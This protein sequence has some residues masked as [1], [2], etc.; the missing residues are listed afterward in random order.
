MDTRK[1]DLL[2]ADRRENEGFINQPAVLESV[3]PDDGEK[4]LFPIH[5]LALAVLDK[6]LHMAA[7]TVSGTKFYPIEN[8]ESIDVNEE[9][10]N[11]TFSSYGRIYTVRAFQESDG[12]W[13]SKLGATVPAESLE[14]RYMVE[15][16]N[17]FSPNAPAD[18]ENLYAAVND[19]GEVKF[20]VYSSNAGMYTRSSEGWFRVPEG[21]ESLD[22]LFIHEM[23]PK[24]IEVFDKAEAS[25]DTI[26]LDDLAKYEVEYRGA[27]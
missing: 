27:E 9:K 3:D 24:A 12:S 18:D 8:K 25:G 26:L 11:I 20:F 23:D 4:M 7:A 22:D 21:D 17:A 16:E 6:E 13:A 1:L 10:G 19:A 2:E 5:E 14:E 15:V